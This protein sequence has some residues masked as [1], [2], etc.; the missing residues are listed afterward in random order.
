MKLIRD[1]LDK[2]EKID[3][4]YPNYISSTTGSSI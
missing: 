3:G 1:H 2:L 4:L